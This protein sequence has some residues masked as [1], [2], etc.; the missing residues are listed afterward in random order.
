MLQFEWKDVKCLTIEQVVIVIRGNNGE[1][2]T[3]LFSST[4]QLQEA[5]K[6]W[7]LLQDCTI[8]SSIR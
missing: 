4:T 2:R 7:L 1:S 5:L 3:F 8:R 6:E